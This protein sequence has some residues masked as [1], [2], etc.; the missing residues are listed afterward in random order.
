MDQSFSTTGSAGGA[1]LV[2]QRKVS[3][4][5]TGLRD[6]RRSPSSSYG[7]GR[8]GDDDDNDELHPPVVMSE[9]EG[10]KADDEDD[11]DDLISA[12]STDDGGQ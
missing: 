11:Y 7:Y 4:P 9:E 3:T 2:R 1:T 8:R 10:V 5:G 6:A 12:Y